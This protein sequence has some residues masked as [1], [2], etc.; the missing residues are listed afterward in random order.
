MEVRDTKSSLL[1]KDSSGQPANL[2]KVRFLRKTLAYCPFRTSTRRIFKTNSSGLG[3]LIAILGPPLPKHCGGPL[4]LEGSSRL[5][6][7]HR[8][9]GSLT[10]P[11]L[12]CSRPVHVRN[13]G[14][15]SVL[16]ALFPQSQAKS[17]L[18]SAFFCTRGTSNKRIILSDKETEL[19]KVAFNL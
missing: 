1:S 10:R 12:G 4:R 7:I 15:K 3:R 16:L 11:R 9:F 17:R 19:I 13:A 18:V 6:C 2:C 14:E 5:Q 8:S